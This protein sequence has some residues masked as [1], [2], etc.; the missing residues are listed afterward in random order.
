MCAA[1]PTGLVLNAQ[2]TDLHLPDAR[3]TLPQLRA[4]L[5]ALGLSE[6]T[7][8]LLPYVSPLLVGLTSVLVAGL[9]VARRPNDRS[10]TT[11]TA[12]AGHRHRRSRP[13]GSRPAQGASGC[14]SRMARARSWMPGSMRPT[15]IEEN[16]SRKLLTGGSGRR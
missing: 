6:R 10:V 12:V 1:V 8:A 9:V 7:Y 13:A 16:P 2:P 4:A 3:W 11:V 15:G 14:V 5:A